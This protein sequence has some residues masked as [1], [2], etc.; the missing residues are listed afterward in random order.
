MSQLLKLGSHNKII[1]IMRA[2]LWEMQFLVKILNVL[3][4]QRLS[5]YILIWTFS[6]QYVACSHQPVKCSVIL[7]PNS[8]KVHSMPIEPQNE[9]VSWQM[10]DSKFVKRSRVEDPVNPCSNVWPQKTWN[11]KHAVFN[12]S[13]LFIYLL[14]GCE[15]EREGERDREWEGECMLV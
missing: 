1:R 14:C 4:S 8:T 5:C 3:C 6:P 10:L 12:Y 7:M 9:K 11:V 2:R 15:G 13:I